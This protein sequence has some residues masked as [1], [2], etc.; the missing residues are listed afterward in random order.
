M[1]AATIVSLA[2]ALAA[3]AVAY[4]SLYLTVLRPAEIVMTAVAMS[5]EMEMSG[6][7]NGLPTTSELRLCVIVS[8]FGARGA[9]VNGFGFSDFEYVGT[10]PHLWSGVGQP[11]TRVNLM[12]GTSHLPLPIPLT[13]N[14]NETVFLVARLQASDPPQSAEEYAQRLAGLDTLRV[15]AFCTY[16]R[17]TG[18]P[19]SRER[20][21]KERI[22]LETVEVN[23]AIWR[24][25]VLRMWQGDPQTQH[26]VSIVEG[27]AHRATAE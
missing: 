23:V 9:L 2:V 24:A 7:V 15:T 4:A 20:E 17:L 27:K 22:L 10:N 8:N 5:N 19:G 14:A 12:P 21:S 6:A 13:P 26:L 1:T 18:R 11:D 25:E 16:R 3:L